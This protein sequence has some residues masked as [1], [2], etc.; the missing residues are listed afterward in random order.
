MNEALGELDRSMTPSSAFTA[1]ETPRILPV[2]DGFCVAIRG[3]Y[4][5]GRGNRRDDGIAGLG[6]RPRVIL[7]FSLSRSL[8]EKT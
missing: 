7:D 4:F 3:L 2:L 5:L 6:Q 8:R 1:V